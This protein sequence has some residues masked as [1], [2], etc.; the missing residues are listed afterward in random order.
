MRP[1]KGVGLGQDSSNSG[2]ETGENLGLSP[3]AAPVG[4][5]L[6]SVGWAVGALGRA[7]RGFLRD[8]LLPCERGDGAAG[9]AEACAHSG[10]VVNQEVA[11]AH[12]KQQI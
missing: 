6:H 4:H 11:G 10:L 1:L 2:P 12:E 3:F 9:K 8:L 5:V 7:E